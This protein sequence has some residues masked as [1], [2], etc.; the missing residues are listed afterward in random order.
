MN[1][2]LS[3]DEVKKLKT[4][5]LSNQDSIVIIKQP[6]GNYRGFMWK[7]GKL[8][9]TRQGDPGTVLSYLIVAP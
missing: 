8:T 2:S 5:P 7:N 9:Q 1:D 6:D 4:N 3:L